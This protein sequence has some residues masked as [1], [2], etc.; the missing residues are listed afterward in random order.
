[1]FLILYAFYICA[2]VFN[3]NIQAWVYSKA[4]FLQKTGLI[5][6]SQLEDNNYNTLRNA[7]TTE[8][9]NFNSSSTINLAENSEIQSQ[10]DDSEKLFDPNDSIENFSPFTF[11]GADQPLIEKIRFIICWPLFFILFLSVPDCRRVYWQKFFLLTFFMSLVWLSL[12]SYLMVWMITV[13]GYTF[14]IPDTVMGITLIAFGASVPDAL[15]SLLVA[16]NGIKFNQLL[17]LVHFQICSF[18]S[19]ARGYGHIECDWLECI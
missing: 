8:L 14:A 9:T 16:K 10:R 15:S 3:T 6:E 2:M 19:R 1:M 18:N 13:I 7:Q 5:N 12:F 4:S 11:P 17:N